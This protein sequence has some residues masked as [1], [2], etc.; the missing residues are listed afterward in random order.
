MKQNALR[1]PSLSEVVDLDLH[2]LQSH[3]FRTRCKRSLD[4]DGV[5][6]LDNFLRPAAITISLAAALLLP[7][8]AM[9]QDTGDDEIDEI[10]VTSSKIVVPR[11]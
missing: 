6:V 1:R 7:N 11:R 3:D 8:A 9:S 10:V 5:L 2:P 4:A